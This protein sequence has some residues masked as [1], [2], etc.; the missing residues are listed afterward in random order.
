MSRFGGFQLVKLWFSPD[1]QRQILREY[2]IIE[3]QD[4]ENVYQNVFQPIKRLVAI[5]SDKREFTIEAAV[6]RE[7]K[8][9]LLGE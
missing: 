5:D 1:Q 9:K 2:T 7:I 8:R 6:E 3:V 4:E